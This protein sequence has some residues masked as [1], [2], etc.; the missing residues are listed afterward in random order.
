M[1]PYL[2]RLSL[3]PPHFRLPLALRLGACPLFGGL[4]FV[5]SKKNSCDISSEIE[6]DPVWGGVFKVQG[7]GFRVP[8]SGFRVQGVAGIRRF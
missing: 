3:L 4:E 2:P 6:E 5:P 8:G 1:I 7:S